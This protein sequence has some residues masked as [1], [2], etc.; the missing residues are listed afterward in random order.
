[1]SGRLKRADPEHP[2]CATFV[3]AGG[4]VSGTL[5]HT[6][7]AWL[8]PPNV[9]TKARCMPGH[10]WCTWADRVLTLSPAGGAKSGAP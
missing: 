9:R 8:T 10:R 7:L 3:A 2:A 6:M 1:M 4:R 5:Q